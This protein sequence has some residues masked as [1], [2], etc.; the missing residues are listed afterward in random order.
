[1][2]DLVVW[3][4]PFLILQQEPP[5]TS[6]KCYSLYLSLHPRC[7]WAWEYISGYSVIPKVVVVVV[8]ICRFIYYHLKGRRIAASGLGVPYIAS[9][10]PEPL[11]GQLHPGRPAV[12][13]QHYLYLLIRRIKIPGPSHSALNVN[14]PGLGIL[15]P[16]PLDMPL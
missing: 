6:S 15:C 9:E 8:G 16:Q 2:G 4:H 14:R 10:S 12:D 13:V 1:M 7:L 5:A 11:D 3:V